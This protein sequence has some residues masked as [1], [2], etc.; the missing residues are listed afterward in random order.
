MENEITKRTIY[1]I[2]EC[3]NYIFS[4][5]HFKLSFV[6]IKLFS[7]KIWTSAIQTLVKIPE[8]VTTPAQGSL[9]VCVQVY[10]GEL[11]V[12]VS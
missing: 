12:K 8:V 7:L 3:K 11:L 2:F 6:N 10:S 4:Q 1:K 9:G 5:V